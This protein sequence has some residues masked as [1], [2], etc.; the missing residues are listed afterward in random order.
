MKL[1]VFF[2]IC[3]VSIF[4]IS[5]KTPVQ[6]FCGRRLADTLALFCP[7]TRDT[8]KRSEELYKRSYYHRGNDVL[9]VRDEDL[10]GELQLGGNNYASR[11]NWVWN[12]AL[13]SSRIKRGV[14][15][16]CCDNPCSLDELLTYC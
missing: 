14:V 13:Q 16:E 3:I 6:F 5:A 8:T 2:I 9:P 1:S 10:F 12:S 15:S 4:S 11:D 7:S